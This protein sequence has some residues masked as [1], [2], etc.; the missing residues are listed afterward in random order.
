MRSDVS[1]ELTYTNVVGYPEVA[2]RKVF[3][4]RWL[5]VLIST[6]A[7]CSWLFY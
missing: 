7:H 4:V 5:I 2:D 6:A 3:P 1:K